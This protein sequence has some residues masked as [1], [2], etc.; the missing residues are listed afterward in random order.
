MLLLR[1]QI[2]FVSETGLQEAG[3]DGGGLY[4]AFM[5]SFAKAAFDV[6]LGFFQPTSA[7]LLFP[8]PASSLLGDHHLHYFNFWVKC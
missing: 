2:E 6:G 5:D 3:I 4:K 1:L 7:E 8:N